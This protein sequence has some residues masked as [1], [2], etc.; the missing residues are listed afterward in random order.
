MEI[1][2]IKDA[3]D[4]LKE[5]QDATTGIRW[6]RVAWIVFAV[7]LVLGFMGRTLS[8]CGEAGVVAQSELGPAALLAKYTWLKEAHAQL[9][10]K[11]ADIAVYKASLAA[12][13]APY[14]ADRRTAWA[15][16]D[17]DAYNQRAT[18]LAGT[19]AS[20]NDLA[21]QYNAKMA[22]VNWRFTNVGALPQGADAPLPREY[23]PYRSE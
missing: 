9:D 16:E 3:V 7:L 8:V 2:M 15:R 20:F 21:A 14:G 22:E 1:V 10:K 19:V 11:Q 6:W 23:A 4:E 13:A 12:I 5:L 17:R 18:E